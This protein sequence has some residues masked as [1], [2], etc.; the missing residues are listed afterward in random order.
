LA[1]RNYRLTVAYDGVAYSGFQ[2]QADCPTIQG[3][4]EKALAALTG[5]F[6]RVHGAGRTDAGVHAQGQVISFQ[7]EW[8]H[9]LEDLQRGMNALLPRDIAVRDAEWAPEGFH[10][11][12]SAV[13]REYLYN[14]YIAPIRE[15]LMDRYAHR[16]ASAPAWEAME[17]AAAM[18][19]REGDFA[20]FGQATAGQS[21]TR[22]VWQAGWRARSLPW[23]L[24]QPVEMREFAIVANGFL[25]GMVRR[26]VGTLIDVG[27]GA[28]DPE[29][30]GQILQ[31]R[32]IRRASPP[33]PAC[34][35]VLWRV[36]Y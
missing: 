8:R 10:A 32:D 4:L 18:L 36:N 20:A 21:T 16:L 17:Q 11:R 12:Y 3:E 26:I 23:A 1:E 29:E 27:L 30:F 14:L 34:G 31:E 2:I 7:A 15:P 24:E 22:T 25:R 5:Q 6:V 9:P 35:L 33:A 19:V 13:S 28:L